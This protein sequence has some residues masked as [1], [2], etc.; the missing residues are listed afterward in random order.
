MYQ[1]LLKKN[2]PILPHSVGLAGVFSNR[3]DGAIA[4][5]IQ[6]FEKANRGRK[7]FLNRF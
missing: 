2:L 4:Y 1:S 7:P 6:D 3:T 5:E